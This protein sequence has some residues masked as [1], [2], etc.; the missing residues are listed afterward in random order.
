MC[1]VRKFFSKIINFLIGNYVCFDVGHKDSFFSLWFLQKLNI[2]IN[3]AFFWCQVQLKPSP[4]NN[5][6]ND[7]DTTR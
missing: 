2:F 1:C 4:N 5:Y 7:D 6:Q 3:L